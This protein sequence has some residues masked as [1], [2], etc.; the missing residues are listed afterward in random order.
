[1]S[2]LLPRNSSQISLPSTCCS[3]APALCMEMALDKV[4]D[5]SD[6]GASVTSNLLGPSG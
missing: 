6:A 4:R 2:L 3:T 1:M 5:L